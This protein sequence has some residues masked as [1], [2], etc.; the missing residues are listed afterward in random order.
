MTKREITT[1]SFVI[2]RES[3]VSSARK[4]F[5][6]VFTVQLR[7][8]RCRATGLPPARERRERDSDGEREREIAGASKS[9][10]G[11]SDIKYLSSI[12]LSPHHLFIRMPRRMTNDRHQHNKTKI[13]S[14][15]ANHDTDHNQ[16]CPNHRCRCINK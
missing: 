10:C 4:R 14:Q 13:P 11:S 9:D 5:R 7:N 12:C 16:Q 3:G 6:R 1:Y 8:R 2:L 15:K